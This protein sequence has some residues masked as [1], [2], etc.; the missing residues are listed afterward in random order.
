MRFFTIPIQ[1]TNIES[2]L[3]AFLN[4]HRIVALDR[5]FVEQGSQS[6][7]A[8]CVDFIPGLVQKPAA[9]NIFTSKERIDYKDKLSPEQFRVFAE[10]RNLRKEV[11]QSEGVPVYTVFSNEQLACMVQESVQS[12]ASLEKIEGIGEARVNKYGPKFL[13]LMTKLLEPTDEANGATL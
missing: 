8:I 4:S 10:L 11:A 2:E 6:F 1:V 12:K 5:K 13:A 9:N 7:W 3:N